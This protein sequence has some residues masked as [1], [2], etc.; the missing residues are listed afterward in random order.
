MSVPISA[1]FIKKIE[2]INDMSPYYFALKALRRI[3][4][5]TQHESKPNCE[6]DPNRAGELIFNLLAS[7]RPCMIARFGSTE[8]STVV[9]YLGITAK[10]HSALKYICD[11][12]PQ[13]WW[14]KLTMRQMNTNSGFF[15]PTEEYLSKFSK[16]MLRDMEQLD[17]LGSWQYIERFVA[18]RTE[19][20]KKVQLLML[21]PFW[22]NKP[23]TQ[24][25]KGKNVV[26][27]HPFKETILQQYNNENRAR[28]FDNPDTLPEFAS[29]RIVKAVQSLGASQTDF[30]DWFEALEW[31]EKEIDREPYDVCLIGCGAYGFPLAA[32]VKRTGH[33][34][35]HLGGALQ[36]LFGIRGKRW[37][38]PNYNATYNH[39]ALVN[40]Y[41]VRPN[42]TER[43]AAAKDVED[44]CYW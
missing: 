16:M 9:N 39:S 10:N 15:P 7:E 28:L 12:E 20:A 35:V 24:V 33:K 44:G 36:L 1:T 17:I 5:S 4:L 6:R 27:V 3:Y 2:G 43:P 22:S 11:K 23:W 40:K 29:L 13:W 19:H 25:L 14:N 26:V 18:S 34:A 8:L 41:W 42:E 30:A 31:M 38:N 32:H 21:E 37:D